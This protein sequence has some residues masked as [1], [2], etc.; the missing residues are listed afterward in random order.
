MI[1]R[2]F[3]RH[4]RT[5]GESYV[6]HAGAAGRF[7]VAMIVAG[8]ACLVHAIVPALFTRTG[9]DAVRRLHDRLGGRRATPPAPGPAVEWQ[10]TYEI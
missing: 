10:L 8:L 4:P 6:E 1:D 2:L 3:L 5:L 7:G 9:S